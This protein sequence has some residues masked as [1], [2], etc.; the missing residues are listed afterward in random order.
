MTAAAA[1][2][3]PHRV[4]DVFRVRGLE[5]TDHFFDVPLDH[6]NPASSPTLE[7]FAREVVAASKAD[8]SK[9]ADLPYLLYLQGGP[10][11]EAGRPVESGGWI[12]HATETHRVILLDQRGTGRSTPVSAALLARVG[13]AQAQADYLAM[14]RADAIV[15]DAEMVRAALGVDRWAVLGQSFGGFCIARYLGAAPEGLREA[16]FTGGLPPLVREPDAALPTYRKLIDRVKAQNAKYY[17]RFPGD[18]ARVKAVARFLLAA[19]DG[20]GVETPSGGRLSARGLQALGFGWLGGAGGMENLHYLLEKA[21]DVPG[22]SLSYAFLKG[23]EVRDATFFSVF[24]RREN[25]DERRF[26]S[27]AR[28]GSGSEPVRFAVAVPPPIALRS[29]RFSVVRSQDVHSFDTNPIYAM[30]HESIYCNGG[31]AS[32]WAAERAIRE[33]FPGEFDVAE[34]AASDDPSRHVLFTGEMV[35][36][37]MFDEIAALRPLRP[38]AE[39]LAAKDDW[40]RLYDADALNANEVPTACASYVEDA[41]VDFDLAAATAAEIRGARVWATSEYMHSG[42]RE[43]G[44]RILKKLMQMARDEEPER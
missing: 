2:T 6:A 12:A 15:A 24:F 33:R 37:F 29:P 17:R 14:H 38:A 4:G 40:P 42:V 27:R 19:D 20:A 8:P 9:R 7:I 22:E 28:S 5:L 16:F 26:G 41:F 34:A 44:A 36:P 35:F 11:F 39:I 25:R 1:A 18:A 3:A 13:D 43:D 21:W 10:G 32:A 31:G 23:A 30:L